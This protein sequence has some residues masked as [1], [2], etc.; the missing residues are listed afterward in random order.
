MLSRRTVAGL[1]LLGL[2]L[3]LA[4]CG[5]TPLYADGEAADVDPELR[6]I[7]VAPIAERVG[8]RLAM[9]L[10]E[11][12]NPAGIQTPQRYLLRITLQVVR[13]DLG[14]QTQGL[15]TR[16]RVDIYATYYLTDTKTNAQVTAD[17]I[18]LA[19]SFD[20]L[21]NE[22]SNVVA[23]EDAR[24]RAVEELRRDLISRLTVIMK[25]RKADQPK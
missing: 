15:G 11:S 23:E 22:Y 10:R 18:H 9:A 7:R 5:W 20:I 4:G 14:V 17:T 19:E 12:L 1:L 25:Y 2:P 24:V 16:G 3:S 6:A 8:Q 13:I 21:A